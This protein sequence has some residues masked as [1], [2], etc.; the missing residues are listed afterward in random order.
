MTNSNIVRFSRDGDQFHYLWAARRC[1]R[2]LSPTDDLVA[3]SIEDPSAKETK[4]GESLEAGVDQIDV[5]E[6]YGSENIEEATLV[7]YIQLK[8]STQNPTVAWPPSGLEKTIR[9]FSERYQQSEQKFGAR[10]SNSRVEF[11]FISNRPISV[12]LTE[13]I[14]DAA[15]GFS[16]R[17]PNI[18]R[19]L[20]DFTSLNGER[21]SAF[22]KLLK[23]EGGHADYWLQR[24]DLAMEIKGY[25]PGN[26]VDAPVQ[27]KELVTRKALSES[28]DNPSITKMDVLR[29]LGTTEDDIF[30]ARSRIASTGNEIPRDRETNLVAKIVNAN[31]PV[32]LHAEGGVGKSVLSQRIGLHLPKDS[33][34][35]VYDCFGNGEYR[36]AGSFRH[37]YKDALVQIA[38][39]LAAL[40]L[41][42]PLI[43]SSNADNTDYLRAFAYRLKQSVKSIRAK[44]GQPLLCIVVDAADNAEIAANEFGD[45]RS[46]ARTLLREPLPDGVRLVFLCR[47]ERQE[48]LDPPASILKLEL[49]PFIRD[50][51][52]AFLRNTY[53]DASENDVDEFHRLT[54]HNPRVQENALAKSGSLSKILRSLGPDSTTVDDTI[55]DLLEQAIAE[56]RER[57]GSAE[58]SQIDS[59]CAG[60]AILRPLV[61]LKVL[62]SVS[63]V[64][65]ST[66]R[67]FATDFGHPLLIMGDTVQF[68]DEPVETWFREHFRPSDEQLSEFIAKL[69]PLASE[70]AYVASTL[71]QL[72]LE[73]GQLKELIGLALSS[74]SLPTAN[75]IEKR[76]VELQRLQFALK[77]SL[78]AKRFSD[79][80]K[81]AL[82]AGEETAGDTR[83]QNLL[84]A[85]TDLAA[86]VIEPER[87]QEIVSR[88]M[89]GGGWVGSHHA[90]EAGLLS[91]I[92]EFRGDARSRLRMAY[93]WI[94]NWSRL[95]KEERK[96][97]TIGNDDIAEIALTRF[98][99]NGPEACAAEMRRWEPREVS[100][101]AGHIVAKRLIDHGRYDDL[102][103]LAIKS[104]NN[105]CLLLAINLELRAVHR[106]PPK[107]TVEH[108]LHLILNKREKCFDHT[109]T[110]LHAITALVES[111]HIY[112]LRR[113]DV[114]ASL[115]QRYLPEIPPRSWATVYSI[116]FVLP[117][118]SY[119]LQAELKGEDLQLV[120]LAHPELREQLE[121][122]KNH[123]DSQELREFKE[124]I[125]VLL[126]WYKLW[127]KNFLAPKNS[128]TIAAKIAEAHK[129]STNAAKFSYREDSFISDEVADIWFDILVDS[130]EGNQALLQEFKKWTEDLKRPLY[131]PTWISLARL[132]ARTP[133]FE[134]YTYEL[135]QRAFELMKDAKE[136]AESKAQT[137]IKLA[138][139]ILLKDEAEAREYFNQA[140]EVA[141]KI[142]D[143]ILDRWSAILN[144][145]D[146][147]ANSSQSYPRTAYEFARCAELAYQYVHR[148]KHFDWEGTV[149]AIAGLCSS[150]CFSILSRWRDRGFGQSERLIAKAIRVLHD[151][152]NIDSKNVSALVG[153]RANWQYSALLKKMFASCA[154]V[155]E[156]E[157]ILNH[158]LHY[159]CLEEQSLSVWKKLKKITEENALV[160]PDIDRFIEHANHR[161]TALS[162]EERLYDNRSRQVDQISEKEW[163]KIFLNLDLYTPNGLS[164]AYENFKS[165]DPPFYREA[166]FSELFKRIP[167]GKE[168]QLIQVFSETAEFDLYD[169]R[170]FL[171]QL[172]KDWQKRMAVKS[173]LAKAI[174]RLCS[175]HCMEITKFNN[176]FYRPLPLK[177]ASEL[178][179]I[180]EP[181]L[182][183]IIVNAVG[184]ITETMSV[185]RL[186]TLAGLLASQLSHDEAREVLNFGLSLF[187]DVLD[188]TDGDGPWTNAL[189]SPPDVNAAVAGYIWAALA[190]P[191]ASL[192]WEAAHVVRGLCVLGGKEV[193]DHLVKL[194]EGQSGGPFV[195]RRLHFYHLHARQWLM[196]ALARAAS[197][198][199]TM[200]VAHTD[201]FIR[202][203]LE[204][205]PHVVI[206]HFAAKAALAIAESGHF[207][208]DGNIVARLAVVNTSALPVIS[209]NRYRRH[210]N[211][212]DEEVRTERFYFGYD[213]SRY[214]FERLGD[215]FAK[216]AS[217]IEAKAEKVI[218][219]DWQLETGYGDRDERNQRKIYR[220][221]ETG[222]SHGSY[223]RTDNLDFYLSYHAMMTVAGKLLAT[224]PLHQDPDD[225]D[226]EFEYWLRAALALSTR[227][228]LVG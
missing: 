20:E 149:S 129:E 59:I 69:Q 45:E 67:S 19:K 119:A 190:A 167:V 170:N 143:E 49:K 203:A 169:F 116:R 104:A 74:S 186:F 159:M 112:K 41:C 209:S 126:P 102:D 105:L 194:A 108:A 165:S 228:Q 197:E 68:R 134:S 219:D 176:R 114:L 11:C 106:S 166:F 80:A 8:H 16:S 52:S 91:Y 92:E 172:P 71:P 144:I 184:K 87:I 110:A 164:I 222:H 179:E 146:R 86:A 121:N 200:L 205:E 10:T 89:F 160:V 24:A 7:R 173:S 34:A 33:V 13:A 196:I 58:Q 111:A 28:E 150:S 117:I 141:S 44:N 182:I 227:W 38:N 152:G 51:T 50:E 100:Y 95:S 48:L 161:E 213:M 168:A 191:Q 4:P 193:L 148:D 85:N 31:A 88:R 210:Q 63:G 120:N 39:E 187:N 18:L 124:C 36:R 221:P 188:E 132:A 208:L 73:A 201:F 96:D 72:M 175:R 162:N 54:S 3:I 107:E 55:A 207:E 113:P 21:L 81:L 101:E 1:L 125:R 115:L 79:A 181:D 202:F 23:L 158:I 133:N 29:A 103:K 135:T 42:D 223:P 99:I 15:S 5:G 56:M 138:R 215:C 218:W 32:I 109:E 217:D 77:A 139:A 198:H 47:T 136:D 93:E 185:E 220:Y 157:K 30:P 192:R 76:D 225:P 177:L 70:S 216:P 153:F 137:Y 224:V 26:D 27:L 40:G 83:Q 35:V 90:Y 145:A 123:H 155:S 12:N 131:I 75:P 22:C 206:R 151:R 212:R 180:P 189:A 25:L 9:G 82:K 84:Q 78:R 154:S 130:S 53:S 60:L 6:Y 98:N 226:D 97:E 94:T 140:I 46:F 163:D 14:E 66:I 204:D 57:V 127:A 147:A 183:G 199:P 211:R 195:D 214:W 178:S 128:S 43:P 37:R 122:E 2:L 142:G 118:R 65:A 61:P 171:E 64:D 156:Q 174:K 17:H 62:A